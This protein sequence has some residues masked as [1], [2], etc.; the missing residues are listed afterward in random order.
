[1]SDEMGQQKEPISDFNSMISAD[2]SPNS[3]LIQISSNLGEADLKKDG[4]E[5]LKTVVSDERRG[6][7]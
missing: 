3:T 4:L 6:S 5:P 1:M 7:I 2:F